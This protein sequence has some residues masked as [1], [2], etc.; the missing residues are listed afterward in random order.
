VAKSWEE[1]SEEQRETLRAHAFK[2]GQ[3]GNPEGVNGWS[4]LRERYRERLEQD[5]DGL[6]NVLIKLA[7]DGDVAALKLA[8][9]PILDVRSLELSG[10]EGAPVSFIELARKAQEE[11]SDA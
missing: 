3:S 5:V 11:N 2:P 1:M 4:K 6:V 10:P 8:L 7:Q 9:G